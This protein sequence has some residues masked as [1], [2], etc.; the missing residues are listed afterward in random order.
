MRRRNAGDVGMYVPPFD[1][2]KL[3]PP[4]HCGYTVSGCYVRGQGWQ[5][6]GQGRVHLFHT[7]CSK[8]ALY[9]SSSTL[10]GLSHRHIWRRAAIGQYE[11]WLTTGSTYANLPYTSMA[12]RRAPPIVIYRKH[13]WRSPGR[14]TL[15]WSTNSHC[16]RHQSQRNG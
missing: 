2:L 11:S 14:T 6:F 13:T 7:C 4:C 16:M 15:I 3:Q 8:N 5:Q 12:H 9:I 1:K 10:I